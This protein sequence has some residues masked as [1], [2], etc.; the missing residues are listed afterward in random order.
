[1]RTSFQIILPIWIIVSLLAAAGPAYAQ[2]DSVALE[3]SSRQGNNAALRIGKEEKIQIA[4]RYDLVTTPSATLVVRAGLDEKVLTTESYELQAGHG[5]RNLT[6]ALNISPQDKAFFATAELLPDGSPTPLKDRLELPCV[7]SEYLVQHVY[8]ASSLLVNSGPATIQFTAY[9]PDGSP[10]AH[11]PFLVSTS[12]TAEPFG[13]D[14]INE[15]GTTSCRVLTDATGSASFS[16][17]PPTLAPSVPGT[18]NLFPLDRRL[19]IKAE[20]AVAAMKIPLPITGMADPP[21]E[22]GSFPVRATGSAGE[23]G[24]K[25]ENRP[26][27]E[28]L[29]GTEEAA[30][31]V[32]AVVADVASVSRPQTESQTDV[33]AGNSLPSILEPPSRNEGALAP[34]TAPAPN[35]ET[36]PLP[37]IKELVALPSLDRNG[38]IGPQPV[39]GKSQGA[40]YAWFMYQD[41]PAPSVINI[42]LFSGII[43]LQQI[44]DILTVPDGS[45]SVLIERPPTGWTP[46]TYKVS[47]SVGEKEQKTTTF[48]IAD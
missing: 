7:L 45:K 38:N 22:P 26:V 14:A 34:A 15:R 10:L 23:P 40:I 36:D 32:P 4:V 30:P 17:L 47:I 20:Q 3:S 1:M 39:F 33:A 42:N 21:A 24:S 43:K 8:D 9:Y 44:P 13:P 37:T 5:Q 41:F 11:R 35:P 31:P 48:T 29:S 28:T 27:K 18:P 19:I 6:L 46:G 16:Y 25:G 12:E 2:I